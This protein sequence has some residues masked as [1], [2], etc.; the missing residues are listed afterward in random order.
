MNH[1]QPISGEA[2]RIGKAILDA[3]FKIHTSLGP[4]MLER[5]YEACLEHE[6][7]KNGFSVRRQQGVPIIY[8]GII[9][10]EGFRL[11]LLIND[12]VII[13]TK[14]VEQYHPVWEAQLISY[15]KLTGKRLG[16]LINFNVPLLKQGV[17][18]IVV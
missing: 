11:D 18:R 6:L 3:A 2:E 17:K 8:D 1:Y 16:Y 7:T 4:G 14:A 12:L 15:L 13:E 9:F 5:V 10:E